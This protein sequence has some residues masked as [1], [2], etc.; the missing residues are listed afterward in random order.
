[1]SSSNDEKITAEFLTKPSQLT[2][3]LFVG[4]GGAG[5]K[6]INRVYGQLKRRADFKERYKQLVKFAYLDT[7]IHDLEAYRDEGDDCFL[8]SDFEKAEYSKLAGGKAY[9]DADDY[10]TQWV[11]DNYR[12]RSGDTAGAGQIRIESRLGIYYQVKHKDFVARFRKLIEGL[13]DHS[14]GHRRLDN[15]EIRIVLAYSVAG[16]TGSGAHLPVAYL[17]RELAEQFGKPLIFGVA[18]L[19]SV[20]EEKVGINK[21]GVFA[22]GYAALK[23]TEYLMKLGAPESKFFPDDGT[24]AFHYNPSDR[25]RRTVTAKPFEALWIVDRPESFSV[26]KVLEA[27]G[28]ALFLQL[29]TPVYGEQ[30]GDFDNY[31]QHQRFLVPHDFEAKNIPG[32]TSFYGAL[33][34]A[35]L[36]VPD[37]SLLQYCAR[38]GGLA[39]IENS[40][41]QGVPPGEAYGGVLQNP[42]AFDEVEGSNGK[43]VKEFEFPRRPEPEQKILRNRLFQKRVRMLAHAEMEADKDTTFYTCVFQHGHGT[44]LLPREDG[45]VEPPKSDERA[46]K[47]PEKWLKAFAGQLSEAGEKLKLS[48]AHFPLNALDPAPGV[49]NPE[50]S[51]IC[52]LAG[53]AIEGATA[54]FNGSLEHWL[55]SLK[56]NEE[57]GAEEE[58]GLLES[59]FGAEAEPKGTS[60]AAAHRHISELEA[61]ALKV[62]DEKLNRKK[63]STPTG[64]DWVPGFEWLKAMLFINSPASVSANLVEKRYAVLAILDRVNELIERL[65]REKKEREKK[66]RE[67]SLA[68]Q[69]SVAAA[70]R[71]AAPESGAEPLR[72]EVIRSK[73]MDRAEQARRRV[74]S[75]VVAKFGKQLDELQGKLAAYASVFTDLQS[76]FERFRDVEMAEAEKLRVEGTD[77]THR[78]LLD[79]EALQIESGRRMWDFYYE[80]QIRTLSVLHT[81]SNQN[82]AKTISKQVESY[83]ELGL[84]KEPT[85]ANAL[86]EL[87][88]LISNEIK[89]ALE[90]KV[91]GDLRSQ[92]DADRFG[93]KLLDAL[94]LEVRYRA[95]Y[96]TNRDKIDK[97]DSRKEARA[98]GEVVLASRGNGRTEK[99]KADLDYLR[100]KV[101]RLLKEKSDLLCYLDEKHLSQGGVRA[102]EILIAAVHKDLNS[103]LL[104]DVLNAS[105]GLKPPKVVTD[106]V[107]D[108]KMVVFYRAILNVPLYVFGRMREMRACYHQFKNMAKRSKVLHIDRNWED[109][110]PDLDPAVVEEEH[111]QRRIRDSVL[112]FATLLSVPLYMIYG[113]VV[114]S[115]DG[116]EESTEL[117]SEQSLPDYGLSAEDCAVCWRPT[118][119][120]STA[121]RVWV[122]RLP[123][124][125]RILM[126]NRDSLG[127]EEIDRLEPVIGT[128]LG[129]T[130]LELQT[131]LHNSPRLYRGFVKVCEMVR[132]GY[133]PL[134]IKSLIRLPGAWRKHRESLRQRYGRSPREDQQRVLDDLEN[135]AAKLSSALIQLYEVLDLRQKQETGLRHAAF[136]VRDSSSMAP[137]DRARTESTEHEHTAVTQCIA[138]L[139]DF[140]D[141]EESDRSAKVN[142]GASVLFKPLQ[143]SEVYRSISAGRKPSGTP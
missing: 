99:P 102:N 121:E 106:D 42:T 64:L 33:G 45:G 92:V 108:R 11:P 136:R 90:L 71:T 122:L 41:L 124:E 67:S 112:D 74:Q 134:V 23:E 10:F 130:V 125:E 38:R 48:M 35:A 24:R 75:E 27:A 86:D 28:D 9:L 84:R 57:S 103:G 49:A 58:P 34:A 30:A 132:E 25:S 55:V 80:D 53:E 143:D 129:E 46:I 95:M 87:N 32:Y 104:K 141:Q 133:S 113:A 54:H 63:D 5:C 97:Q 51:W 123:L 66:E 114:A 1:M 17:L 89:Q 18:A 142:R 140:K 22:N 82:L 78:F 115:D 50:A 98:V 31:T 77:E 65:N 131:I 69:N 105:L 13:K 12:F 81:A 116:G 7:N 59:L 128:T 91:V 93:L 44:R 56:E 14:H 52:R 101:R 40:F 3:T 138:L 39:V 62:I 88:K 109:T 72:A 61:G 137:E 107:D 117:V 4:L 16:G 135:V 118:S 21:D 79:G 29:F 60:L 73:T 110:L 20:F 100:D 15:T 47:N 85:P 139:R 120:G 94:E 26:P 76:Q 111:R 36:V 119:T 68:S 43:P 96:L 127:L 126:R 2:P 70:V 37:K 19:S 6:M 8:I 83:V